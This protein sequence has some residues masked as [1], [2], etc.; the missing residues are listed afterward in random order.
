MNPIN[1]GDEINIYLGQC[2]EHIVV[3]YIGKITNYNDSLNEKL[4]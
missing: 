2:L 1:P 3:S 4:F